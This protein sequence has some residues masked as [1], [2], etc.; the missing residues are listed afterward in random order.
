MNRWT[1]GLLAGLL[2]VA[3]PATAQ[4]DP[5]DKFQDYCSI[6]CQNGLCDTDCKSGPTTWTT[7]GVFWGNPPNDLDSDGVAN[8]N[9]NCK[10]TANSNQAN[11]D[12]DAWGDACDPQNELWVFTQDLGRCEYDSDTHTFYRTIEQYGAK[13]F[14]NQCTGAVCY[15]EYLISDVDCYYTSSCGSSSGACCDCYY[16]FTWCIGSSCPSPACPF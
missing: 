4:P 2:L 3:V 14:V 13:K 6:A 7:C 8:S 5:G 1:W 9:D 10:C 15:D 12:G 11:C 16:P